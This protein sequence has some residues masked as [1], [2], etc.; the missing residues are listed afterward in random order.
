VGVDIFFRE[1]QVAWEEV[2][3]F[4]DRR[5]LQAAERLGLGKNERE[6]SRIATRKN[7]PRLVA[8]LVRTELE[9]DYEAVRSGTG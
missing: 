9:D 4:A 2:A 8:A 6:L 3:P 7:F 1:V 5:A